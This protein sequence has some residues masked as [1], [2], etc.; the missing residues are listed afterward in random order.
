MR[1][2]NHPLNSALLKREPA[3]GGFFRRCLGKTA[4][5][6]SGLLFLL[7][8][9]A[10]H[11]GAEETQADREIQFWESRL[12]RDPHDFVAPTKLGAAYLQKARESGDLDFYARAEAVL[13]VAMERNP[14]HW[15]AQGLLASAYVAR[16]KFADAIMTARE[17]TKALP[18]EPFGYG[19]LGDALLEAGRV[20]EAEAAFNKLLKLEPGFFAFSR[21]ANLCSAKGGSKGALKNFARALEAAKRENG[22]AENLAWCHVQSGGIY[23]DSGKYDKAEEQYRAALKILPGYYVALEHLG[24]L[25]AAQEDFSEAV[26]LYQAAVE[27]SP[28]PELFHALG[29]LYTFMGK[30]AEAAPW[31]DRALTGYRESIERGEVHYC[32]HLASFYSGA[33]PNPAEALK[34][35]RKDFEIRQN[36]STYETLAFALHLNGKSSEAVAAIEK[37]LAF[38]ASDVRLFITASEIYKGAGRES[39]A[40]AFLK[41]AKRMNPHYLRFH[42]SV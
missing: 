29:E 20:R 15:T 17:L 25:R 19:V 11:A 31:L 27:S 10:F 4:R 24:E 21:M 1:S 36:A 26:A 34:W 37:A 16:H 9:A 12:E 33:R 28:R 30:P 7:I 2:T 38:G 35:A 3:F 14:K 42:A 8:L 18:S 23:F 6:A 13:T 22:S 5:V 40:K 41:R 32:H 39:K